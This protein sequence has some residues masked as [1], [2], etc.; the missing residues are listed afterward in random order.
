M[1]LETHLTS[2][3][4]LVSIEINRL[5]RIW[6]QTL[7]PPV[8]VSTLYYLI[9]GKLIGSRIGTMGGVDYIV[10]IAPGLIMMHLITNSYMN[11]V[12][13]FYQVRFMRSIEELLVSPMINTTILLG[14]ITGGIFRGLLVAFLVL[15]VTLFF[16]D[17]QVHNISLAILVAILSSTLMALLG[18]INGMFARSFDD[19]SVVTTFILNPFTYLGGIF[20]SITILPEPW[21]TIAKFNPLLYMVNAFRYAVIGT[22]DVEIT[23]ALFFIFTSCLLL[24][25]FC[26]HLLKQG[27]GIRN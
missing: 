24:F 27:R 23:Y 6:G 20:F 14:Y 25:L 5:T 17:I 2:L 18:F 19:T 12:T 26:L 10:Y 16:T 9:F 21:Q 1:N 15:L 11:V 13:S 7:I 3:K 22:T 8:I 4:T